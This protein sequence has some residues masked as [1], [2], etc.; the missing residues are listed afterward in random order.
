MIPAKDTQD[1]KD[2]PVKKLRPS[3]IIGICAG[4]IVAVVVAAVLIRKWSS[5]GIYIQCLYFKPDLKLL[6]I[7]CIDYRESALARAYIERK[8]AH[9]MV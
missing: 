8:R 1:T 9:V 5:G 2:T 7:M 4:I 3:E 6:F